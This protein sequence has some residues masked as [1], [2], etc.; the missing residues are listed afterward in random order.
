MMIVDIDP[1]DGKVALRFLGFLFDTEN[2]PLADDGHPESFRVFDAG[3]GKE[4]VCAAGVELVDKSSHT[5][6]NH[7]VAQVK[8]ELIPANKFL[9]DAHDMRQPERGLLG[10]VGNLYPPLFSLAYCLR[11]FVALTIMNYADLFDPGIHCRFDRV[12]EDR[13][14]GNRN[15]MLVLRVGERSKPCAVASA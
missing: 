1:G 13:F 4:A 12:M 11:N 15:E 6:D 8:N 3:K 14:I 5:S 2:V 7:I 9:G 10:D